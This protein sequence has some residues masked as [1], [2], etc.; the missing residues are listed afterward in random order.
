MSALVSP[1]R[2][3][4][5][6]LILRRSIVFIAPPHEKI[7]PFLGPIFFCSRRNPRV[8]RRITIDR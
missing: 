3:G 2:Q 6:P 5:R 1:E 8:N 7:N 4:R